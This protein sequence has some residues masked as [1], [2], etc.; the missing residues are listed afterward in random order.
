MYGPTNLLTL[1]SLQRGAFKNVTLPPLDLKVLKG[2]LLDPPPTQTP[3]PRT[4]AD[5][6]SPR[7]LMSL[8]VSRRNITAEMLVTGLVDGDLPSPGSVSEDAVKE[9]SKSDKVV[10]R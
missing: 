3:A 7:I 6:L 1:R 2:A 9:I 10:H 8:I 4:A 5:F